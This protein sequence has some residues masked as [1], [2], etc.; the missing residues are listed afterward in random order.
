VNRLLD[1]VVLSVWNDPNIARVLPKGIAGEL[2]NS[3]PFERPL[4]GVLL[5]YANGVQIE[6]VGVTLCEPEGCLVS[7][8]QPSSAVQ[9]MLEVPD[10]PVSQ[11]EATLGEERVEYDG[12]R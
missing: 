4:K 3:R 5:G 11:F 2:A 9:A 7:S 12:Q 6:R 10:Y 1:V 8:G